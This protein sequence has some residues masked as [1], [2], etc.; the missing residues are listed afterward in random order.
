M[1]HKQKD[2]AKKQTSLNTRRDEI[3]LKI[4]ITLSVDGHKLS[5]KLTGIFPL[6]SAMV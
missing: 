3:I 4:S 6:I 5:I 2:S 1:N